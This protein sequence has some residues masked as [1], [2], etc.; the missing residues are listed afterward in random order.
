[1][2][3]VSDASQLGVSTNGLRVSPNP[4]G[5]QLFISNEQSEPLRIYDVMGRMVADLPAGMNVTV[6]VST[7]TPG[8]Y[9]IVGSTSGTTITSVVHR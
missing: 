6:D 5:D 7:W 2:T 4:A 9:Q 1:V 3:S 8:M